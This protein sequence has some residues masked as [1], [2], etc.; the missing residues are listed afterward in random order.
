MREGGTLCMTHL[1]AGD[2]T[3]ARRKGGRERERE[4][5]REGGKEHAGVRRKGKRG[6]GSARE[7]R[8]QK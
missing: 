2:S 1:P 5:G 4:K 3:L 7:R 8:E 6:G